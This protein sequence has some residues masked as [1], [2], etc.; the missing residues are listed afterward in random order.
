MDFS[1]HRSFR[2]SVEALEEHY[3]IIIPLTAV[4]QVTENI[5][6][7]AQKYNTS[8]GK[9]QKSQELIVTQLDGSMIPIV[10]YS[11]PSTE[12]KQQG[13]KRKRNCHWKEF[14]LCTASTTQDNET[15]YGVTRGTPFEAGCM[16]YQTAQQKG[17]SEDTQIHGVADGAPWIAEQY[18]IQFGTQHNFTLDFYH[19]SE[20]LGE[21]SKELPKEEESTAW[22]K[23]KQ[24]QLKKGES[25][26]ALSE[27]N[28]ISEHSSE[29]SALKIAS[30]YLNNRSEQLG[31]KEAIE[32]GLPIGSGEV[33]SGH[34]SVLQERLKKTGAWWTLE[35][36]ESMAQLKVLQANKNWN[37]FWLALP[38]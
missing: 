25:Q 26:E 31:Y 37:S 18:D 14:R 20:Y 8:I 36:A 33:E 7:K 4:Q 21:A 27:L 9:P 10:E 19:V 24:E 29:N 13:M 2:S 23:K 16:M 1:S 6:K 34:R 11:Q 22:F 15:H 28:R 38:S 17:M 12:E 5:A 35:N 30:Q 32:Q 3:S